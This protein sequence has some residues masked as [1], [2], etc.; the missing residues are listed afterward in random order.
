[1]YVEDV[2]T[3]MGGATGNKGTVGISLTYNATSFVFLCS[4]FAAGQKEV[5]E[6]NNDYGEA[7]KK[8]TFG[9]VGRH[10][11]LTRDTCITVI[12]PQG[13]HVLSHDYVFWCGDFN[14]RINMAR[15]VSAGRMVQFS[16]NGLKMDQNGIERVTV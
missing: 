9:N 4:H 12:C 11:T 14:Y 2:K 5:Q 6:R 16:K 15:Q 7:V 1:M 3:G 10:V 8:L 13:R